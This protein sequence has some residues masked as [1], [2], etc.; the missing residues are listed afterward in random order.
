MLRPAKPS[1]IPVPAL[2]PVV[3]P[4]LPVLPVVPVVPVRVFDEPVFWPAKALVEPVAPDRAP[5]P[6]EPSKFMLR[7]SSE[8]T[9]SRLLY[10]ASNVKGCVRQSHL[11]VLCKIAVAELSA[12]VRSRQTQFCPSRCLR[13]LC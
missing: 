12:A 10:P 8:D 9:L 1:V 6:V 11:L 2:L 13:N 5:D 4:V 3:V 7:A